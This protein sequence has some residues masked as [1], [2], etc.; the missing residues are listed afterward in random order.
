MPETVTRNIT[1][2]KSKEIKDIG[3]DFIEFNN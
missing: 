1:D 3:I 2:H